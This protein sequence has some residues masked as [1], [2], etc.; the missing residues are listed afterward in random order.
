MVKVVP[1]EDVKDPV[2]GNVTEFWM[3]ER[4]TALL[5]GKP[6]IEQ[7]IELPESV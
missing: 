4:T 5:W 1:R 2:D 3:P 6:S 7:K